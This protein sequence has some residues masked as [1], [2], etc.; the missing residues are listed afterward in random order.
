MLGNLQSATLPDGTQIDYVIDGKDRRVG[1]KVNGVLVQGLL[2][3]DQLN[4]V[5]ELDGT[6]AVVTRFVYGSKSNVPDYMEKSGI[7]YR[8]VS[9]HLGSPLMV[10]N[11]A[12]GVTVAQMEYDTFGN[13]TL[14]SNPGF[15]PFGFAGGIYDQ[16]TKLTRFGARDYDAQTGRWTAKDPIRFD[17]GDTNLYGY[18][19]GD[20]VN[21][22]D[23]SGLRAY[24]A[25]ETLV[26]LQAAREQS[27]REAIN[28]HRGNGQ[29]YFAFNSHSL[30]TFEVLWSTYNAHEFG[31]FLA[32]YSG[33]YLYGYAGYLG[34]RAAG[35]A[36]NLADNGLNTDFDRSS[37]PYIDAGAALGEYDR[38]NGS[39]WGTRF[40]CGP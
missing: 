35:I 26:F 31:N 2:Y 17:G 19:V 38:R 13:V 29:F 1:K 20:P 32:G 21:A 6:G 10:V 8:I 14:D 23:F 16:H 37:A 25:S 27:L 15:Q 30:D 9:D 24:S 18:V 40:F 36:A 34:V 4:P 12:S 33:S 22:A 3:G 28:N 39:E 7:T 5:A 11:V